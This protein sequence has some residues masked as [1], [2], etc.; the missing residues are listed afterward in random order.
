MN[1]INQLKEITIH[2]I[3]GSLINTS[4]VLSNKSEF[5]RNAFMVSII[6]ARNRPAV[7]MGDIN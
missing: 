1:K 6:V 3:N 4:I 2:S 7:P 5:S